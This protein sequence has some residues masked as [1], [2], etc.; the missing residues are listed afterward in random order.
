MIFYLQYRTY[1]TISTVFRWSPVMFIYASVLLGDLF[2]AGGTA[3]GSRLSSLIAQDKNQRF[4]SSFK[5]L[6]YVPPSILLLALVFLLGYCPG[7]L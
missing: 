4:K 3:A 7:R 6:D 1:R 5:S 2:A